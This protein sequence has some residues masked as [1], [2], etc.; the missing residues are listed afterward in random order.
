VV[1][2]TKQLLVLA[3]VNFRTVVSPWAF[4]DPQVP[5]EAADDAEMDA[6]ELLR[7]MTTAAALALAIEKFVKLAEA[8]YPKLKGRMHGSPPENAP[9]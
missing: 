8:M 1:Y 6:D 3:Q 4:P 5:R 9:P 2:I 7:F